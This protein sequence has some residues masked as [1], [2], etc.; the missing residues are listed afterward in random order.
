MRR[1][2]LCAWA[3]SV[4]SFFSASV[5]SQ[6]PVDNLSF[7][8]QHSF[9][10]DGRNIAGWNIGS[11]GHPLQIL[12][13]RLVLT[14]PAPGHTRGGIWAEHALNYQDW[15]VDV[16]F[17]VAGPERASGVLQ[18]WLATDTSPAAG[19]R[20]I[21]TVEAFDGLALVLD[22]YSGSAGSVR[23]FLNDGSV[24]Y[25]N[26]HN[27][28]TLAFGHCE[29]SF[30]N[31]GRMSR[32]RLKHDSGGLEVLMDDKLCFKSNMVLSIRRTRFHHN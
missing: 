12:S 13:D 15:T 5:Y 32:L 27:V 9:A 29:K 28:D 18:L 17:R 1:G 21:Y 7:G 8:H 23:G 20:S 11:E 4:L 24:N 25:K 19:L 26:H 6:S 16:D 2:S 14:P 30:R 10:P 31:L 3:T 22:Q